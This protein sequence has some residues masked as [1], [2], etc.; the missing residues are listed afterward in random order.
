VL[1]D[2][3]SRYVICA[4]EKTQLHALGRRHDTVPP[5]PGRPALVEFDYLRGGT[6]AYLAA[7]DVHHAKL[8]YRVEQTTGIVPVRPPRRAGHDRRALRLDRGRDLVFVEVADLREHRRQRAGL[9]ADLDH[10]PDHRGEDG[11]VHQRSTF[12][13]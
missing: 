9:L 5:G 11:R 10:V 2:G 3:R 13:V 7:W 6:L 4:D 12:V 8:F 1:L